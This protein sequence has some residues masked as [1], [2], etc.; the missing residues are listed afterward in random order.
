V[1]IP[2]RHHKYHTGING[3]LDGAQPTFLFEIGA[4]LS[5]RNPII[6]KVVCDGV[7]RVAIDVVHWVLDSLAILSVKLLHLDKL[8]MVTAVICD[9][10]CCDLDW[11]CAVDLEV[12]TWA[13]EVVHA[14]PVRLDVAAVLVTHALEAVVAI[15]AAIGP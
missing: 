4:I 9:E 8:P 15:V 6:A 7:V 1:I 11:L 5:G 3:L 12:R 14:Q 2:E 10:L 13:K